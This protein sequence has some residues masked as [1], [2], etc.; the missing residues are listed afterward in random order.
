MTKKKTTNKNIVRL[1]TPKEM[2]AELDKY[3]IGQEQAKK[4]LALAVYN[5]YKRLVN[6]STM[7][8]N[9]V[10]F[11]K[12]NCLIAGETGTGKTYMLQI[13]AKML[14]VGVYIANASSYTASGYV[15]LDVE[16]CL[17]G[18]LQVCNNNVDL[19][20]VS[21]V[22]LDEI[23]KIAKKDAGPSITRDVSGEC[24][25]QSFL[26]IIEGDVIGV[27]QTQGRIHPQEKLIN[28]NTKNILFIGT[29]AFVGIDNIIKNRIGK[30]AIGFDNSTKTNELLN[31]DIM[32][33]LN[34]DDLKQFGLIPEFIGRFPVISHTRKL[35]A[36]ELVRIIKEPKNSI[37]K[38]YQQM[39][40]MDNTILNI[41]DD[42]LYEIADVA[43]K[44]RTGARALRGVVEKVLEDVMFNAADNYKKKKPVTVTIT[45]EYV[46]EQT[47][48]LSYLLKSA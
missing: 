37:L 12:S 47:K 42:A 23:D 4:T 43:N 3:V 35:N 20:E 29:G 40:L 2:V 18:L 13:L 25:Q 5:H 8:E 10:E 6:N 33:Y 36:D 31:N 22:C 32:E 30:N 38:Q 21:I 24:V 15:G 19:A 9:D 1:P 41:T 14:N 11:V 45:K 44:L 39:L 17:T 34:V 7:S 28:V 46:I 16:S 27:P 48:Y 26:K